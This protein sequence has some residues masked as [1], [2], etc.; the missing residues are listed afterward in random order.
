[1]INQ[2]ENSTVYANEEYPIRETSPR[3][4]DVS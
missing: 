1:M 3:L 4:F 2:K